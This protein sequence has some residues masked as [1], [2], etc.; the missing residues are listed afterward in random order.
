QGVEGLLDRVADDLAEVLV[1]LALVDLD[2]VAEGL[3]R[4]P[5]RVRFVT[6]GRSPGVTSFRYDNHSSCRDRIQPSP[7]CASFRTL[8]G[9]RL[10]H[11]VQPGTI[12]IRSKLTDPLAGI[13]SLTPHHCRAGALRQESAR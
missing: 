6:H 8:S 12:I 10:R 13:E 2:H 5:G 4:G 9:F 1:Q 7:K 3:G 11:I